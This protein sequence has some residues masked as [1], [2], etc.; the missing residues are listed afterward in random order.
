MKKALF[1]FA[2]LTGIIIFTGNVSTTFAQTDMKPPVAKKEPK[3]TKIHGYE[4]V[5]DYAWLR[6]RND[7]KNPEIMQ[8]L[9]AENAYTEAYMK[10]HQPFIDSLYNEMLGRIK[11][12]DTSVPYK[13]GDYWYFNR[14]EKGKQYP[15]YLRSRARDG[16]DAEVLLDQNEMAKGYKYFSI[17]DFEV[18]DDGNILAFSTDTTGFRQYT[19]QFKDLR[20]GK[21]LPGKIERVTSVAWTTDNKTIFVVTEDEETKRSDKFWRHTVG[22]DKNDLVSEEKDELFF[23]TVERTRD[24]KMIMLQS[25]AATMREFR[26]LPADQP[27]S[28]WKTVLPREK[29]H[30]YSVDHY[31]GEFYITTNK[32]AENF[33]VVR[34]PVKDPS[35][36]NWKEF[37]AHNPAIKIDDIDFFKDFAVVSELEN[38]LE[39]LKV[40]DLKT[41]RAPE[42]IATPE[43]VYT[44]NMWTN[45]EFD[46]PSILFTYASMITPNSTYEYNFKTRQSEILKQQEIPSGYDKTKYETTRVWATARDG[47]KVPIS[48]MMKKGTKLDGT[49]PMLLY[50]Y[51]SYGISMTPSFTTNRLSLVDRGMI[52]AIAHI[53][54]GSELGEKWRQ[55]G[56]M[57]KKMNTFY[58]FIDSAKWLIANKYTASDR[59]VIQG[60]SAGGLLMG[61][62]VNMSPETFKA[63]I[64]QVPF[65]DVMN[66]MLDESLP[67]TT[68][69]WI[70]WGNPNEK[71]AFDY[72]IKYS[73]YENL[74]KQNYPAMLVE[75]SLYDSQVMYWEAAKYTARLRAL[76]TDENVVLL[77][78]NMGAGHGG[79]SGRF[80][81]LKEIA[82]DYAYAL[83]QVGIT[84]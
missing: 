2:V 29:G 30:E 69:E 8:Y 64:V 36:K 40:L 16:K 25:Y 59:L 24:K 46:A 34:A 52:Y 60:G 10:P 82:F 78:T 73:P 48:V 33:R 42:R 54:G 68:G 71:E 23:F 65:V 19:L 43:S 32:N 51:G 4:I 53:R 74:K 7:K 72:M 18:S 55:E 13:L 79:S 75:T 12:A 61:A 47:V 58:D 81:R 21:M 15:V 76:K 6:D 84:K 49:S 56:R 1:V 38:G 14:T 45:P 28:E 80:D 27:S 70:E 17:G 39:Y 83:S 57:M 5:D 41:R 62:V 50:A 67:L 66:T 37:I 9:E 26:Y 3:V 35:E 31:M 77:K 20:T 63:A 22:T 44:M 11:Q